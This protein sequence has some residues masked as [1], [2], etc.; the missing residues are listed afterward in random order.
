MTFEQFMYEDVDLLEIYIQS[1]KKR[2]S[3]ESWLYGK[4]NFEGTQLAIANTFSSG[5][6]H[7]NYPEYIDIEENNTKDNKILLE[8]KTPKNDNDYDY[9]SQFY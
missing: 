5:N 3:L 8:H 2:I 1:Y 7:I 6:K 9:L 4:T